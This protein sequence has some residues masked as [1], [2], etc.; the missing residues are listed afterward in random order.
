VEAIKAAASHGE[1]PRF[2]QACLERGRIKYKITSS[3]G[4]EKWRTSKH[5]RLIE[6]EMQDFLAT[7]EAR[8]RRPAKATLLTRGGQRLPIS[9]ESFNLTEEVGILLV[10]DIDQAW[11]NFLNSIVQEIHPTQLP[12]FIFGHIVF[13]EIHESD[14]MKNLAQQVKGRYWM[15]RED[16]FRSFSQYDVIFDEEGG[17]L[18]FASPSYLAMNMLEDVK[19]VRIS[20]FPLSEQLCK[21]PLRDSCQ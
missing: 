1:L 5:P 9:P 16:D 2:C 21:C 3:D 6:N 7:Y 13:D 4:P 19:A 11:I 17:K 15:S 10:E 20:T 14:A 12:F 18:R 8:S